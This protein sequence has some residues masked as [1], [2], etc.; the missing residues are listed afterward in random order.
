MIVWAYLQ[1]NARGSNSVEPGV[2]RNPFHS[3]F[4]ETMSAR[5]GVTHNTQT[6][7]AELMNGSHC[8][9]MCVC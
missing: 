6:G 3:G 9:E 7:N 8:E 4:E 1:T 2:G 5:S